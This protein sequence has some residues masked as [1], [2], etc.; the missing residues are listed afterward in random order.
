MN[1]S[2]PTPRQEPG[3]RLLKQFTQRTDLT[4]AERDE[5]TFCRENFIDL[6]KR[7]VNAIQPGPER[8]VALRKLLE[9]KDC[10]IRAIIFPGG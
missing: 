7:I 2:N 4:E 8:T 5:I 9:A 6:A 3:E 10:A 1:D